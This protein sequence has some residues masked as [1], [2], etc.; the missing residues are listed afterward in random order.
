MGNKLIPRVKN[1]FYLKN[2]IFYDKEYTIDCDQP[3][4]QINVNFLI[5]KTKTKNKTTEKM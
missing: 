3:L 5:A 1:I 2:T 4:F